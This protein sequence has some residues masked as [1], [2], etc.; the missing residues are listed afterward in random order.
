[1][2]KPISSPL[3]TAARRVLL[4]D[5]L[6]G[7]V[8]IPFGTSSRRRWCATES[9][10]FAVTSIRRWD[11]PELP[12]MAESLSGPEAPQ[13][14]DGACRPPRIVERRTAKRRRS[15]AARSP[16][17]PATSARCHRR[18][19]RAGAIQREIPQWATVIKG[20]GIKAGE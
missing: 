19:P 13:F 11:A 7:R 9:C 2:A 12:T 8:S 4:P 6:A 3:P 16:K 5:L 20:A 18:T 17:K 1:M 15:C 14:A 10:A